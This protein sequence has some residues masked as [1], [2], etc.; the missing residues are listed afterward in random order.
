MDMNLTNYSENQMYDILDLVQ[1]SDAVLEAKI[2][3]YIRKYENI[4]DAPA[5]E[6]LRFFEDMYDYFFNEHDD[7]DDDDAADAADADNPAPISTTTTTTTTVI[8]NFDST[9]STPVAISSSA[10]SST[11]PAE[12]KTIGLT[13]QVG[14]SE[15]PL[16]LNPI[17]KQTVT[18]LL[19]VD[20]SYREDKYT[21]ATGFS[22]NLSR[23]LRD[24]ISLKLYAVQIPYTWWTINK[25]FG[26]NFFYFK[27]N[28]DGINDGNHD[29]IVEIPPGNY[30]GTSI[31]ST[32]NT[33]LNDTTNSQCISNLY[34]DVDFS[35]TKLSYSDSNAISTFSVKINKQYTEA[36][37]KLYFPTS[38][39]TL[40][41]NSIYRFLG[42]A[43][44]TYN[45][46]TAYSSTK[47]YTNS[48][49]NENIYSVDSSN[50]T[51]SIIQ[52][53]Q[54]TTYTEYSA[55]TAT[56]IAT[57]TVT[58]PQS[59]NYNEATIFAL[60]NTQ[61]SSHTYLTGSSI[62]KVF[63]SSGMYYYYELYVKLNRYNTAN[64]AYSKL[65][66]IF[67]DETNY[68]TPV[69]S[70]VNSPSAISCCFSFSSLTHDI[71]IISAENKPKE[72]SY[73]VLQDL[74]FGLICTKQYYVDV[75][76]DYYFD[77]SNSLGNVNGIYTGKY[78]INEYITAVNTGISNT[79]NTTFSLNNPTGVLN[80]TKT[81]AYLDTTTLKVIMTMDLNKTFTQYMFDM[82]LSNSF[83]HDRFKLPL[84]VA[85]LT[86]DISGSSVSSSSYTVLTTNNTVSFY[87]KS[88]YGLSSRTPFVM[89]FPAGYYENTTDLTNMI[90]DTITSF[91]DEDGEKIFSQSTLT[92]IF[93]LFDNNN[94]LITLSIKMKKTITERDYDIYFYDVSATKNYWV[95]DFKFDLSYNLDDYQTNDDTV[96]YSQITGNSNI[97]VVYFVIGV[98]NDTFSLPAVAEGVYCLTDVNDIVYTLPHGQYSQ[99]Q[100]MDKINYLLN[101]NSLTAGSQL[102]KTTAG[103]MKFRFYVN[104]LYT[105]RDYRI[106]YYDLYSFTKCINV[107]NGTGSVNATWDTTL[108]WLLGFHSYKE[109][110]LDE[111]TGGDYTKNTYYY[112]ASTNIVTLTG[113]T[114]L[115]TNQI[116]YLLIILNDYNQSHLNNSLV[117]VVGG[118]STTQTNSYANFY[119]CSATGANVAAGLGVN[120][121]SYNSLTQNQIYAQQQIELT[122][123]N[124]STQNVFTTGPNT[125]DI[126]AMIPM[127]TTGMSSGQVY[128]EFGGSLQ[129]QTREY[130][131]PVNI[132]RISVSLLSNLGSQIDLNGA[133]WSFT[134]IAEQLYNVNSTRPG[135]KTTT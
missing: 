56:T 24:V 4:P 19:T 47:I 27:G 69:W 68:T 22:F 13:Q 109:Y 106:V 55:D 11:A 58:L 93:D 36:D 51:L 14:Y 54:P 1:P 95:D 74:S 87:P 76:N 89:T 120:P 114:V 23:P 64:V 49:N 135:K 6:L 86:A 31:T 127:K 110:A 59:T 126:F 116:N 26:G 30:T 46:N 10:T 96:Y 100:L 134:I 104:K 39:S 52:Y 121:V 50:C 61:L 32:I 21:S 33:F 117:T 107:A 122:N 92:Y 62:S 8:E 57:Y 97:D 63:D 84:Y 81:A 77:I 73:I 3:Y 44:N 115:I 98:S 35:G 129:N 80:M 67:P 112:D 5:P 45:F 25:N 132:Q 18:T 108:G 15:D 78:V 53:T 101:A 124:I 133:D 103:Y 41:Y 123:A 125:K 29:Y 99:E 131:G 40:F 60:L 65:V 17:L 2:M 94:L 38:T 85:D 7:A 79:N 113:D 28:V 16:K 128:T 9:I 130:F 118:E 72:T 83:L 70:A 75:L 42:Y 90:I 119:K 105:A 82:D 37:Y 43:T 20:S 34:T 71:S 91:T 48:S 12:T 88:G 102:Y 66:V 111:N